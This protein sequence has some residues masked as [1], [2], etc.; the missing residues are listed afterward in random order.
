[1]K[2]GKKQVNLCPKCGSSPEIVNV[3][4]SKQYRIYRC[5][6]CGWTPI[7]PNEAFLTLR[8]AIRAWN[9]ECRK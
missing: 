3:G 5:S 2:I 6:K 1:M 7:K 8:G 9:K 4:D